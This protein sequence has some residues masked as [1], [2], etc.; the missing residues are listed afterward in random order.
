[1]ANIQYIPNPYRNEAAD[2]FP[3]D[4]ARRFGPE[5][6]AKAMAFHTQFPEF[7]ATPLEPLKKLAEDLGLASLYV[8]DESPRFGLNAFKGLGGSYA[9]GKI[10]ARKLGKD[11]T[12]LSYA[13]LTSD[14]TKERLGDL[15]FV[16]ATD[17]N[18]GR[19]VA[20]TANKLGFKSVVY[21]PKGSAQERLDNIRALGAD[22][23]ITE[24][25]YDDCVRLAAR[26]AEENGWVL[27]QDTAWPGYEDVPRWIMEGY[28]TMAAEAAMQLATTAPAEYARPTHVFLQAGVGAMAG[29]VAGFFT[30]FYGANAPR[31]FIVEPVNADCYYRTAEANDGRI[32][33]YT[34]EMNT[35]MAG[36]A[37]GEP[38]TLGWEILK[39]AAEGFFAIPDE[40]AEEGMRVL[41]SPLFGDAVIVSGESG[42]ATA[43]L[44]AELMRNPAHMDLAE[45]IGLDAN[46]RVLCFSTEGATDTEN[47]NRI[48][49]NLSFG[50]V[51][52]R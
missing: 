26:K 7:G 22:A 20:W 24:L 25:S 35:I 39:D 28:T 44:V 36:L 14:E 1:M 34:G 23:E 50:G 10:V 52:V 38:C 18:H 2:G 9:I 21:M 48:V 16:T 15:T 43:G 6:A 27:V 12:E 8:K 49:W 13:E 46:A 29:A 40:V 3:A 5:T 41:G 31:I 17:G 37:C 51:N 11:L 19:G 32:H 42:A 4:A 47:Y 33:P 45:R 30:T